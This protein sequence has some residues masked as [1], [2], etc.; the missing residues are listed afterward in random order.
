MAK[1]K[2]F[3][4]EA[5]NWLIKHHCPSEKIK[6]L[7]VTY[8]WM[9]GENRSVDTMKHHCR[10]L[11]LK[12]ERRNFT[13]EQDAWLVKNAPALSVED[14]AR[15]FNATFCTNRSAQV[16]KVRCNRNL[17]IFH[18]N[19]KYGLGCPIGSETTLNGYVWVKVSDTSH[20]KDSFYKNWKQ[21]HRI[22]WEERNGPVPD[23]CNIVFLDKNHSNCAIENLYAVNGKI[24]REMSKK[25]WWSDNPEITLAALKW[26]ELFYAIKEAKTD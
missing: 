21:K 3:G 17:R 20:K 12:Q 15:A 19:K 16:L 9:F 2:P 13:L 11:G 6:D 26:C 25:S 4:A 23:G 24:L 8:N 22:V 5:D 10:K 1:A 14:T 7:T 18:A